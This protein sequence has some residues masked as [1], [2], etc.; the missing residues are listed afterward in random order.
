[1]YLKN[2]R[3]KLVTTPYWNIHTQYFY[4]YRQFPYYKYHRSFRST[5]NERKQWYDYTD[6]LDPKYIKRRRCPSNIPNAWD[7]YQNSAKKQNPHSWKCHYK[8]RKQ[9]MKNL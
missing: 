5:A 3:S 7:D 6:Q 8:C 2:N 9:W 1:M 4:Q